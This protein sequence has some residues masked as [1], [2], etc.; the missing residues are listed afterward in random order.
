MLRGR[1]VRTSE[2]VKAF[3]RMLGELERCSA[4]LGELLARH[5]F[6]AEAAALRHQGGLGVAQLAGPLAERI[7]VPLAL[8]Q[9]AHEAHAKAQVRA[10]DRQGR[11]AEMARRLRGPE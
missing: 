3:Y 2:A 4:S 6:H 8:R 1:D 11:R 7:D 10:G 5:G 9:K